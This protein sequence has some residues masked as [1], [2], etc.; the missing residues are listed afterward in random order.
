[1]QIS[2][3]T[4][5]EASNAL[6]QFS[7]GLASGSLQGEELRSVLEQVPRLAFGIADGLNLVA[8]EERAVAE[9]TGNLGPLIEVTIGNLRKLGA[10]GELSTDKLIRALEKVS[11]TLAEEFRKLNRTSD[12]AFVQLRNSALKFVEELDEEI[13]QSEGFS[14]LIDQVKEFVED[15]RGRIPEIGDAFDIFQSSL[16]DV[17]D[18]LD[19]IGGKIGELWDLWLD[20][21][22]VAG[23][24]FDSFLEQLENDFPSAAEAIQQI[25]EDWVGFLISSLAE[26]PRNVSILFRAILVEGE[27]FI[28]QFRADFNEATF[29]LPII[30]TALSA[31][32]DAG[33]AVGIFAESSGEFIERLRDEATASGVEVQAFRDE[34]LESQRAFEEES[35]RILEENAD[36]REERRRKEAEAA[37]RSGEGGDGDSFSARDIDSANK[38]LA[39]Y[40]EQTEQLAARN[41]A[42]KGGEAVALRLLDIEKFRG[43]VGDEL[44]EAILQQNEAL[45]EQE[46]RAARIKDLNQIEGLELE[47][48]I[49]KAQGDERFRLLAIQRLGIDAEEEHIE[50]MAELLKEIEARSG[51]LERYKISLEE[52]DRQFA[53]GLQ[54]S[55]KEFF[56]NLDQG[57]DGLFD[58]FTNLLANMAAEILAN[59]IVTSF[60]NAFSQQGSGAGTGENLAVGVFSSIFGAQSGR[61]FSRNEAT[62]VGENGPEVLLPK[63]SGAIVPLKKIDTESDSRRTDAD[64][65]RIARMVA[66]QVGG[67]GPRI[68][69][70]VNTP[71]AG[72]FKRSENQVLTSASSAIRRASLRNL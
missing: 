34:Q 29:E 52:L 53:A 10:E 67:G 13:G 70:T 17:G 61:D 22:G 7:Q 36:R 1:V 57:F 46:K 8:K 62:L 35:T 71:D 37:A 12:Q 60:F 33:A 31:L 30:G 38:L 64:F 5:Q 51:L 48:E 26:L 54:A 39:K 66:K 4:A 21:I 45:S 42:A 23:V 69:M 40:R 44:L 65:E 56:L 2:G 6:I 47:L 11:P 63:V 18:N 3:A 50:R 32:Q 68:N 24:E 27:G 28:K 9:E 49:L 16:G 72:S 15:A 14:F 43:K 20:N 55:F 25:N 41:D 58:S 59:Q 19:A